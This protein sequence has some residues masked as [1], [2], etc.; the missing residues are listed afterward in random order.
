MPSDPRFVN[1]QVA[2]RREVSPDLW[3]VRLRS[4]EKIA[5]EP[6]QYVTIG[7]PGNSRIVER[8]Y[9]IASSPEEPELEFFLE[10]VPGGELTPQLY[11]VPVGGEVYLRRLAKGRFLF[12]GK[13]G[14]P[15]HFMLATVTGIAPFVSMLRHL[16]AKT[17]E[18]QVP[19]RVVA[20]QGASLSQELGY[21]DELSGRARELGWFDYI[22][23]LSRIWLEPG[24]AGERGRVEDIVRKYLDAFGFTPA[25]TT[26]YLCGNPNM[27]E[28]VRGLLRRAGFPKE[29]VREEVFWVAEKE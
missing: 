23:T 9:S 27:V 4:A 10:L 14:H 19:R 29:S 5:F 1:G 21:H 15:N 16:A 6:G 17:G 3:I 18:A 8:P 12:D 25:D 20:I 24:W 28:T 11:S 26:T 2:A 7:L 13:S 22:P